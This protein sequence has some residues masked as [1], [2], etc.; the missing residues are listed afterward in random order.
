[1]SITLQPGRQACGAAR[2]FVYYAA[3]QW[4]GQARL[5]DVLTVVTELV[6]NAA[7]HAHTPMVLNLVPS[8][9]HVLVELYD[10]STVAPA[11]V[12]GV[13][14]ETGLGLR[15]VDGVAQRWGVDLRPDGKVVWAEV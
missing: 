1:M 9:D 14:A 12:E 5:A 13:G 7:N 2:R 4:L 10:G 11:R 3:D 8:G 15:I 6:A